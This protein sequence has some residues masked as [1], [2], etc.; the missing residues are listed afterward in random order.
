MNK[1]KNLWLNFSYTYCII[2]DNLRYQLYQ[3]NEFVFEN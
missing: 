1:V 2:D 3:A